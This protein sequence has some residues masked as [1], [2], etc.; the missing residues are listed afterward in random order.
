MTASEV[1]AR[2]RALANPAVTESMARFALPTDRALG[3][4][5]PQLRKLAREIGKDHALAQ[6]LWAT[7]V[8]EARLLAPMIDEPARVSIAQMEQWVRD[9]DSWGI[10]D[11]CCFELF[12]K[13]RL[14][15]RKAL[16]WSRRQPE[17]EKRAGFALMAALARHDR[18]APD[19]EF[20][21]FLAA[22]ERESG[23]GRNFV[24]K[25]VNWALRE[26]GKRNQKLNRAAIARARAIH[27][28]GS[29]SARWIASDALRE[30]KSAAVQ[31]RLKVRAGQ[32]EAGRSLRIPRAIP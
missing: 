13:T 5:T 20:A 26:I 3:V 8:S 19:K 23:D 4:T 21:P 15:W 25:A 17:F 24:K 11:D 22:I 18:E 14:A 27:T 1:L 16:E 7:E 6:Q 32:P 2:L 30:L 12:D 28:T 10:C 29:P 9:L 31:A